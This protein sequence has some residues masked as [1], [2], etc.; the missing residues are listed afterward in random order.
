M[1]YYKI[2]ICIYSFHKLCEVADILLRREV[3]P[4]PGHKAGNNLGCH[5]FSSYLVLD[6]V[7]TMSCL[8][9]TITLRGRWFQI[10]FHKWGTCSRQEWVNFLKI[11]WRGSLGTLCS[12]GGGTR[13]PAQSP[14]IPFS[15]LWCVGTSK[16]TDLPQGPVIARTWSHGSSELL[17]VFLMVRFL[18]TCK[19]EES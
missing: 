11:M 1:L 19:V 13:I 9:C 14:S 2:Y 15:I 16:Q 4:S 12:E 7:L 18:L 3:L 10:Q 8:I 17:C 5:L 6:V